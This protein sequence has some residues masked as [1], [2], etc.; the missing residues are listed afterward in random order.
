MCSIDHLPRP[1]I[2]YRLSRRVIDLTGRVNELLQ[3][4]NWFSSY[5]FDD[6]ESIASRN[7]T[8]YDIMAAL[9]DSNVGGIGVYG[10]SGVGKTSLIRELAEKVKGNMFDVVIMVNVTSH[11]DIHR[12][13]GQIADMLGMKFEEE[14]ESGRAAR[15]RERL[16]NPKQRTL[17]VLDNMLVNLDFNALG[18]PYENNDEEPLARYKGC[19]ILM[20]SDNEQ[21]LLS[22]TNWKRIQIFRVKAIMEN[23]AKTM[24]KTIAGLRGGHYMYE[25][26]AAQIAI[27]CKGLPVTIITTAKALKYKSLTVW[28]DAY[29]ELERQNLTISEFSTKL[30]YDLLENEELKQTFLICACM[31]QDALITD[32]VRYCIGLGLLQGIDTVREARNRVHELVGKLKEL[33][34][35]SDSFSSKCFTMQNIIRDAALSIASQKMPAFALTKEK[36]DEWPDKDKLK[37]YTT[38]SLQHCDVTDI[39]EDFPKGINCFKFRIFHLDNKDPRLRIPDWIFNGMKELR[40]LKLTGIYLSPLPSSIKCLTKLRM[41]CLERCKLGENISILGELKE[42]RVL[43]LSGSDIECL[44]DQLRQLAKLQI[45]DITNCFKLK[46]IPADVLSSLTCLEGLYV[47]N[48]PIQWNDEGRQGNQSGNASLSELWKL[49]QLTALDIQIPKVTHLPKKLFFDKLDRYK[50]VIRDFNAYWP[51]WDFKMPETCDAL[52]YLALQLEKGF[53]I[54]YQKDIKILFERVENL[55]LGQLNDVEDIFYELNREGF[56]YLKYLSI[57]RNSKVKS[58]IN[59]KNKKHLVK[60]FPKLESL[61]LYE[62]NNMEHICHSQLIN[63]SLSK[64]KIIK[65]KMC[66]Q[67]K[68]VFFS[69]MIK[70][71]SALETIEVSECNSL[72]V[73]VTM[74]RQDIKDQITFPE[75]RSL[76]LQSLSEFIGF[77]NLGE[78]TGEQVQNREP[79]ELFHEKVVISKLERMELSSIKIQKIWS[80]QP[81]SRPY[82]QNLMHLDVNDCGNMTYLL[83]LSMSK[84][85][86]NLQ[87]LSVSEC[88]MM[89]RI[90]IEREVR[91]TILLFINSFD[92]KI[93]YSFIM[94]VIYFFSLSLFFLICYDESIFPKL[95]IINLRSMKKL[96]EIWHKKFPSYSF[97]ELDALIIEGC[98][99]LQNVFPSYMVGRFQSL[100]NLKVTNCKSMKEIF[101]LKGCEKRDPEDKTNLQNVHVEALPKLEHVWN[102][103]P[104]G[105]LNFKNLRKIWVQECLNLDHIFPF[106]I[107]TGLKKLEYLEVWNCG[108]L[109]EIVSRGETNNVSIISFEFPKLT[110]ARFLK[111]PNLERFYEGTHKLHC[112]TLNNLSVEL[113]R[114]L[115][116]FRG[117][118]ENRE[119]KPVFLTEEVFYTLK[120]MQIES[121]NANRLMTYMENYPMHKLEEFQL[122]RLVDTKILYFFLHRNPNLKS[123]LL[124]NCFFE[125]LVPPRSHDEEKSG[126]VP[127]L[128]SLKLMNLPSL[129]MIGFEED[130]ILFQRLECLI[131][132]ECPCLNTIAPSS[133][134]FTCLTN[135]EVIN[136]KELSYLMTPSTAKSLFQ[137]TTMKV[138]QCESMETIVSEQENEELEHIIFRQLKEIELVSLHKLES[139][140][141]S[142]C[143]AIEFPSL[144]KVVASACCKMEMFTF[145]EQVNKTPN[146]RQICVTHGEEEKR[147]YWEGDLNATIRHVYK[148][149][150]CF[151]GMEDMSLSKHPELRQVWQGGV[152]PQNIHSW[153]YSLKILKLE[154]SDIQPCVIPSNIL[155]YLES[156][157]EL[158]VRDCSNVKV[159]F[160]MNDTEVGGTTSQLQKLTLQGLSMLMHVWESNGKGAQSFQNLQVVSVSDCENLKTVFPVAVAKNLKKIDKLEIE[161]CDGLLEIVG[162]EEDAAADVTQKFVFPCLATLILFDL[163][164]LIY[165]YPEAF[166]LKCP[167]LYKLLVFDCPKLKLFK[168]ADIQRHSLALKNI[169]NLEELSLDWEHTLVL[170]SMLMANLEHLNYIDLFFD[171]DENDITLFDTS[172]HME[173]PQDG[174]FLCRIDQV[175]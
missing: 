44:P 89:E 141:S 38:I 64:L 67:L 108:Q 149:R 111:L 18:I 78:S 94:K 47:G 154:N 58:I 102:E 159:I 137:L 29:L 71:V 100:C 77:Y 132:K 87:S 68:D 153:F 158:E 90:F 169:V 35:L 115:R 152:D 21:V 41:L 150:K 157:K 34:L 82:F 135:M 69:S 103:D 1:G 155:L 163:P 86:M 37:R 43:S 59:S 136:C 95:K 164:E 30:S 165:F 75:L 56:P 33:S 66:A 26:L 104:K 14:S 42:L 125:Q 112:S 22:Q 81:P 7:Q 116:L 173:L 70:H 143:C 8:M 20:I 121:H 91:F 146:L 61:F 55:L 19:K 142:N 161:Y 84:N 2:R 105:I 120:S 166:T 4:G 9:K 118:N 28:H 36:L 129:K 10:W 62:V 107:A 174:I 114:K 97:G 113:C 98:N 130:T 117:E 93:K 109:K 74:E 99:K 119:I 127:K 3:T 16:K 148:I 151:E 172:G 144:E 46:E 128:K 126:I 170:S 131:L 76:K 60:A 106:S 88:G 101:D 123:L 85:L 48:S 15:L 5:F 23:D 49:S 53:N 11:L 32:L 57:V 50:I 79:S 6:L 45:F 167:V 124:S 83:S 171:V 175:K 160:G 133:V 162:K 39:I 13:Q 17:I 73:I 147:L 25:T 138:I 12:I 140:C 134:S 54:H 145:S 72:K 63:D 139:F 52:R 168:S 65:L 40:V 80:D 92:F 24:F 96:T 31:G 51:V 110:T 122:S 27:K 156:L